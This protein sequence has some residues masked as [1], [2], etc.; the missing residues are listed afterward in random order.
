[1]DVIISANL[2]SQT[3]T[4]L[5]RAQVT[6]FE[7][8][9]PKNYPNLSKQKVQVNPAGALTVTGSPGIDG[10]VQTFTLPQ[11]G[12]MTDILFQAS[13]T[14]TGNNNIN[15]VGSAART[16]PNQ[17]GASLF[18]S[19]WLMSNNKVICTNTD[20]YLRVRNTTG[21]IHNQLSQSKV[22]QYFST[23]LTTPATV[24]S[25]NIVVTYVPFYCSFFE[26]IENALDLAFVNQLQIQVTYNTY[27]AMGLVSPITAATTT[28]WMSYYNLELPKLAELRSLNFP[29]SASYIALGY[30]VY[31]E[32]GQLT[33]SL[34][35]TTIYPQCQNCAFAS[36]IFLKNRTTNQLLNITQLTVSMGGRVLFQSIPVMVLN[37]EA[38]KYG[39][40]GVI[41][42][43]NWSSQ[44]IDTATTATTLNVKPIIDLTPIRPVTIWWGLDNNRTFNSGAVSLHN[45][46]NLSFALSCAS[47]ST[48]DWYVVTEYWTLVSINPADGNISVS[49]SQ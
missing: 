48:T 39:G 47:T 1:M 31:Q 29:A 32:T 27:T 38:D 46:S 9:L 30:D 37:R 4:S 8:D 36:H 42:I 2:E 24:W 13:L 16:N 34:T 33:D 11:Y 35:S 21:T 18:S 28:L 12:L 26:R 45:I 15:V 41:Q 19:V 14:T 5:Q 10:Q 23:D 40:S 49:Q 3:L 6:S 17:G 7:Y 22:T 25:N 43:D 20:G 44:Q